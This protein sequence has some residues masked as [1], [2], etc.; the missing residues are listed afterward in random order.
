MSGCTR[1]MISAT[2]RAWGSSGVERSRSSAPGV[3]RLRLALKVAM[4]TG[5][6]EAASGGAGVAAGTEPAASRVSNT[7]RPRMRRI[8][9]EVEPHRSHEGARRTDG[10][11]ADR[12]AYARAR[13]DVAVIFLVEQV[14]DIELDLG[15]L[16]TLEREAVGQVEIKH[17]VA[18][19]DFGVEIG[20]EAVV[21]LLA[22]QADLEIGG[23]I[24]VCTYRKHPLG[25]F[26][27]RLAG[28]RDGYSG[29]RDVVLQ[30]TVVVG[31]R[32]GEGKQLT[33]AMAELHVDA[34]DLHVADVAVDAESES[35]IE[36]GHDAVGVVDVVDG[37]R[38]NSLRMIQAPAE[39]IRLRGFRL[40]QRTADTAIV[41]PAHRV[42]VVG[43][44]RRQAFR[45]R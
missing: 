35:L 20:A 17:R 45:K 21:H 32:G 41:L 22:L 8:V 36:C 5:A 33:E 9:S 15:S 13:A 39:I 14:G 12:G 1:W 10:V 2:A 26:D 27:Q 37:H 34:I 6:V 28:R 23:Y 44:R 18:R 29:R 19:R 30:F 24:D 16:D 25:R 42:Q 31:G 3:A 40:R 43:A 11:E 4:R 38:R 7:R